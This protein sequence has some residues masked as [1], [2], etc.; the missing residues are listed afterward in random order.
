MKLTGC[1]VVIT[2]V[3]RGIGKALVEQYLEKGCVVG[4]MGLRDPQIDHPNFQFYKTNVR[5]FANVETSFKAFYAKNDNK[6][7][8]LVNN[9]G[10]GYFG[11][12]ED[13]SIEQIHQIF[14]TNVYGT[15]YTSKMAVP[16]MKENER[17]HIVNIASTAAIEGYP[18]VSVYCGSKFAVKGISESM[19]KELRDFRVKVTCVYPGSTKTDFFNNVDSIQTHD[20]MLMPTD[21]AN[22]I[23]NATETPDNFHLV[24]LEV[25]P[26]QPK[27]PRKK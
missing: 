3:S 1:K 15:L 26:L 20:Y 4:G 27:G 6:I 25:R 10:L 7:D 12:V 14:E 17:G 8:I 19:Y 22:M 16:V 5:D 13:Y 24:N 9:A 21:V 2:G 23:V 11:Y 18:Q